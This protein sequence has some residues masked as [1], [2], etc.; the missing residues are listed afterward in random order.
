MLYAFGLGVKD[1]QKQER[2]DI[3]KLKIKNFGNEYILF[4]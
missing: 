4:R 2:I 1:I 3:K